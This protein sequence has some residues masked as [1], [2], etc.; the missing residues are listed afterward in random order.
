MDLLDSDRGDFSCRRAVDSSSFYVVVAG[1]LGL[2]SLLSRVLAVQDDPLAAEDLPGVT[3]RWE[4]TI[5]VA[6]ELKMWRETEEGLFLLDVWVVG[7]LQSLYSINE[8][9]SVVQIVWKLE[10]SRL[11]VTVIVF[12]WNLKGASA[13]LLPMH[14]SNF[15]VIGQIQTYTCI[16]WLLDFG[17]IWW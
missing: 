15:K 11:G 10:A 6:N 13:A 8:E 7:P 16:L 17:R 14:L 4:L 5:S 1:G 9:I 2:V 12:L 3:G